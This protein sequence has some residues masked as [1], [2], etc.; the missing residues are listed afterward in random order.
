MKT[1]ALARWIILSSS[2]PCL[3]LS[4]FQA[5]LA[6]LVIRTRGYIFCAGDYDHT[7]VAVPLSPPKKRDSDSAL[8][9][10]A[11]ELVGNAV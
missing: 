8:A 7:L 9:T 5:Y 2:M 11:S 10:F 4:A 1:E 6:L 3:P